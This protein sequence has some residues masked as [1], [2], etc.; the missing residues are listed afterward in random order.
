MYLCLCGCVCVCTQKW[1]AFRSFCNKK[2]K[3]AD[4]KHGN[5]LTGAVLDSW[6][7]F[8]TDKT[9]SKTL[10]KEATKTQDATKKKRWLTEVKSALTKK[11]EERDWD[12]VGDLKAQHWVLSEWMSMA[13]L[14]KLNRKKVRRCVIIDN[15][16]STDYD[17]MDAM[18]GPTPL[19]HTP[20]PHP[21]PTPLS[22]T[23]TH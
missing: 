20:L 14:R 10:I 8:V 18:P 22:H 17:A 7:R 4:E 21:A 12:K 9:R 2:A 13:R 19:S 11:K 5:A 3:R 15:K 1:L 6:R 23:H 16:R